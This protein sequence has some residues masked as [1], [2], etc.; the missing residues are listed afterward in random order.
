[1]ELGAPVA[2]LGRRIAAAW[3]ALAWS[4]HLGVLALMAIAFPYPLL[5][6]AF[7]PFFRAE[8]LRRRARQPR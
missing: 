7:L 8:R 2:L 1:V 4:F 6:V 3:A 5:G